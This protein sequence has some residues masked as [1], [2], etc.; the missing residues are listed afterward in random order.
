MSQPDP[1]PRRRG[2]A[3]RTAAPSS[4]A[5]RT[6]TFRPHV[7]G[8][9]FVDFAEPHHA[10]G[11]AAVTSC[12]VPPPLTGPLLDG[13]LVRAS[14]V[15]EEDGRG[16][17]SGVELLERSRVEVFGVVEEGLVLRVDPHVGSGRWALQGRVEDLPVGTAVLADITGDRTADPSDEWDDPTDADALLERVRVRHRLPASHPAEVLAEADAQ[18]SRLPGAGRRRGRDPLARRD[19]REQTTFTI[20][21]PSSRD[22]DDALSVFPADPD[23][24]IRVCVHIADVAAHVRPGTLVDAEARRAATSVY[25]PG[26]TRPMLPNRLSD[27]ALSLVPDADRDALTVELRIAADGEI[28]A[29]DV[30][31]SRIR[32]DVRLSYETAAQVLAGTPTEEVAAPVVEALR[33]LRTAAARLGVQR[34]RRGGVEARRVE[35]ELAVEVVEGVAEQVAATPSNPANLLIERLMVAANES[36]AGW[37]VDRGLPGVF[38]VHP[39]PGPDAAPALEA[40]CAAAGFHPGFGSTLTPLGLSALSSQLDAAA[41]ET[42]AAVWDVLLGFLGRATYTPTAGLHF[43]LSSPGYVHFTSPLRR[44]A[45]LVVHRTVHAFL[46]G[47]RSP[48]AYPAHAEL[49]ELCAHLDAAT[50]TAAMAERQMRKALWLVT[51]ARAV[52][53]DPRARFSGRVTGVGAKGL[54]V[55]LDGSHVSGMVTLRSLPGR[56]WRESPDGLSLVDGAGHRHGYGDAVTVEVDSA[57]VESGQLEL[58]LVPSARAASGAPAGRARRRTAPAVPAGR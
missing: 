44:Y 45:D 21:A 32:S 4:V 2:P 6:G 24:G 31:A 9:G 38:R 25:L 49:V 11:G 10:A 53:E 58:R 42:S 55:T 35:P 19:L 7:R 34:L 43:G 57:D 14:F 18:A 17:A 48:A 33:W 41:D 22:L 47:D 37:L 39:P 27:D 26:W 16:T 46:A 15:V 36:V 54:F 40:F 56:G 28:T 8:F 13:D 23:G 50:R 5:S 29:A 3:A 30:Y 1:R 51:L 52:A 20:D 12:F